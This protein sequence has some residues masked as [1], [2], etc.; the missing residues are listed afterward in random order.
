MPT[1]LLRLVTRG[2][3]GGGLP[4]H[5]TAREHPGPRPA[6]WNV[7]GKVSLLLEV[8]FSPGT[9]RIMAVTV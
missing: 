9:G 6:Y 5:P 7:T 8:F 3:I 4:A 2:R 1:V